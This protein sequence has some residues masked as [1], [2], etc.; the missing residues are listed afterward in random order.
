[1]VYL[2]GSP[3]HKNLA[4]CVSVQL[5]QSLAELRRAE[6]MRARSENKAEGHAS[7]ERRPAQTRAIQHAQL[8]RQAERTA[9]FEHIMA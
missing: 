8:A 2:V 1:M 9:R 4:A 5:T 3:S 7:E 6:Q